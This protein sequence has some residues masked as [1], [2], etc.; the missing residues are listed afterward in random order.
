MYRGDLVYVGSPDSSRQS[1]V[2]IKDVIHGNVR[3]PFKNIRQVWYKN[4]IVWHYITRKAISQRYTHP[5]V[6]HVVRSSGKMA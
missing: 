5:F 2:T 1:F 3:I 4:R 6:S